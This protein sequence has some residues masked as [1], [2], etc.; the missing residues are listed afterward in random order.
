MDI[1][2]YKNS[3]KKLN[4][5][6][7]YYYELND[8]IASDH[9]YDALYERVKEFEKNNPSLIFPYSPTQNLET[10]SK[11]KGFEGKSKHIQRM[12]SLDNVF[13]KTGLR[14][15]I[16]KIEKNQENT[17]FMCDAKF[18]GASLNL[19]Y[20]N[21]LLI[22]AATRGDGVIGERIF[23]RVKALNGIP[24]E[25]PY[26]NKIEIRGEVVI[27]KNDF[28]KLN[29][30][31]LREGKNIFA[32]PRNAA[33]GSM[34]QENLEIIKQRKLQ[35]IPWGY[36][37]CEIQSNSYFERLNIIKS[38]GFIDTKLSKLCTSIE[39]I[40]EFYEELT[41]LRHSYKIMLDGMVIRADNLFLQDK[42]GY[43]IKAPRFARAYKFKA[44]EKQTKIIGVTFQVGRTGIITPVAELEMVQIDGAN[45]RRATL[46]NFDEIKKKDIQINDV[47]LIVRS[48]DVI[49]KIIKPI[50]QLRDG[51]QKPIIP[52][53]IC[54]ECKGELLAEGILLKCQNLK[55]SKRIKNAIIHFCSKN[56]ANIDGMGEKI[57]A[58]LFENK[59]ISSIKDIFSIKYEDLENK[60]NWG[61]KKIKNLLNAIENSR[62]LS[63]WRFIHAL[64]I[65]H[66]GV[67]ASKKIVEIFG[68]KIFDISY[69]ELIQID[70]VG[71]EMALSLSSFMQIN[72]NE[73][74]ELIEI[75]KPKY[76]K[77][78]S[79]KTIFSNQIIAITGSFQIS[80]NIIIQKLEEMGAKV[81]S[82][83]TKKTTMLICGENAGS[84]LQKAKEMGIKIINKEKIE[85]LGI[86]NMD[87]NRL[88]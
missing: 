19:K 15:W 31:M 69:E 79:N 36:G 40:Q 30:R 86:F 27:D 87:S 49:P 74:E 9:D 60:E 17:F 59:I 83:I 34:R 32:N 23:N 16:E 58:F 4:K 88:N 28:E 72:K 18:D 81:D 48:G 78:D 1:E 70:G 65:E 51:K 50:K 44:I 46:H 53:S 80:R 29:A 82:N 39:E 66:I 20:E 25:I 85:A 73:I 37:L 11:I 41:E 68:Y 22:D 54:P 62:G 38:F 26:K 56:A 2:E 10:K 43:T 12:W 71:E 55:C 13:D 77:Q 7:K 6:A 63:L 3:I 8:P 42:L 61:E 24:L 14:E 52:P 84:K 67:G 76:E 45:V 64:G 5:M 47:V 57:V 35:F 75:I 33:S 21:G